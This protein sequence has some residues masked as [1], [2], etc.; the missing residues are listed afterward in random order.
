MFTEIKALDEILLK[1]KQYLPK[2]IF[3]IKLISRTVGWQQYSMDISF[4]DENWV[5]IK[6]CDNYY[7]NDEEIYNFNDE[8]CV[9]DYI[10]NSLI[11]MELWSDYS[12]EFYPDRE[13]LYKLVNIF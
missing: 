10:H 13:Y 1:V 6:D 3:Y 12:F 9:G 2:N 5:E 4:F 11:D 8:L 7:F